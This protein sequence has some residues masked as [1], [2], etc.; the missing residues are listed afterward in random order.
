M[1]FFFYKFIN[2]NYYNIA[3]LIGKKKRGDCRPASYNIATGQ[4]NK[5]KQTAIGFYEIFK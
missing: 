3:P 2:F 5:K 1:R 4:G